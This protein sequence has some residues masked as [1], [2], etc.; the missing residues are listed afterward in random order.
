MLKREK[1][2]VKTA[3]HGKEA[4]QLM[5]HDH[6]DLIISDIQMPEMDGLTLLKEIKLRDPDA[7]VLMITAHGS[8]DTAVD[9]MKDGAYDFLTKPFKIDDVKLR[10]AK[11]LERRT[12]VKENARMVKELGARFSFSSI[13]GASPEMKKVYEMIQRVS[14]TDSAVLISADSGCGKELVAKAVHY[15]SEIK[16]K[17]FIS[18]NCGAIPENLIES[19]MFGHKKGSFTGAISDRKGFFEAANGG[20]LFLDEI[21]EMPLSMQ[22]SLLRVLADGTYTP[23]GGEEAMQSKVR[24]IAA[25]NRNLK[26]E[27]ELGNFREDLYFRLNVIQIKIPTLKERVGDVPMLVDYFVEKFSKKFD[28][29]IRTIPSETMKL[30]K[31]YAWPGNVR[32]LENIIER[33]VALEQGSSLSSES[34]PEYIKRPLKPKLDKLGSEL[35]W[36]VGGVDVE[37][38]LMKVEREFLLKAMEEAGGVKKEAA[39]LLNISMRSIRY[40]LD[41]LGLKFVD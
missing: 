13:V 29:H 34:L 18:V 41:K 4:L 36:Q 27:V 30:L 5:N 12:L 7:I 22:S 21:G 14:K 32:E 15:N 16:D 1:I 3:R 17:P 38:I 24:V 33:I 9:A 31:N 28:K 35:A 20:S 37:E 10:I 23:V 19:E 11:A 8:T 25:T 2:E 6:F 40:R 26:E 39:K